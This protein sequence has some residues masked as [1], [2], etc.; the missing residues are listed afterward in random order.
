VRKNSQLN[1]K[2]REKGMELLPSSGWRQFP[3]L[4]STPAVVLKV[5]IN[6]QHTNFQFKT[7]TDHKWKQLSPVVSFF[8]G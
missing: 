6:D 7:I 5:H 2:S 4:P 8:F 3:A 1:R